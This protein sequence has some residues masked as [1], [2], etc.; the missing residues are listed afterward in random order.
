MPDE[1]VQ[2][3]CLTRGS[4]QREN[5]CGGVDF[6]E[7]KLTIVV[8]DGVPHFPQAVLW[9]RRAK[10]FWTRPTCPTGWSFDC[11]RQ[12]KRT[13][14]KSLPACETGRQ[15]RGEA[16]GKCALLTCRWSSPRTKWRFPATPIGS[17]VSDIF[18]IGQS[19]HLQYRLS[20]D[21]INGQ[22]KVAENSLQQLELTRSC[23]GRCSGFHTSTMSLRHQETIFIFKIVPKILHTHEVYFLMQPCG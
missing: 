23:S 18:H 12:E 19:I 16:Q 3:D 15:G 11:Q 7:P 1:P 21:A 22:S 17:R 14:K 13:S 6:S 9:R 4:R 20:Q 5:P 8:G 2:G 10:D